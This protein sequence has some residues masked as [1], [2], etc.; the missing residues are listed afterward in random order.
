[1]SLEPLK[2]RD[3]IALIGAAA[4]AC[5]LAAQAQ[6]TVPTIGFL[7]PR[8]SPES[9]A[10]QMKGFHL[11]LKNTGYVAGENV[12]IEYRWADNR[13]ERL[14]ALVTELVRGSVAV[15]VASGGSHP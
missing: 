13:F 11:G 14:P 12:A 8:S 2:R 6:K 9:F 3:F 5:P 4:A 10:D 1:M 7:D 15:V